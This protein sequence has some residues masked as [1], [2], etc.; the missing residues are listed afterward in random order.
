[1]FCQSPDSMLIG[2]IFLKGHAFKVCTNTFVTANL[3]LF[4]TNLIKLTVKNYTELIHGFHRY[5]V[6]LES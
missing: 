6:A 2:F 5:K 3:L 4:S 1:M